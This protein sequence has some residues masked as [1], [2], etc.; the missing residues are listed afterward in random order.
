MRSRAGRP[1]RVLMLVENVPIVR[2]HRL[3]K[4]AG[5]LVENGLR[6]TVICPRGA[7]NDSCV[8]GVRVLDYPAPREGGRKIDFMIEYAWSI[9]AAAVLTLRVFVTAGFDVLQI[10]STPDIYFTVAWPFRLLRRRI[11]LDFKDVSP[12]MYV[13][14][15]GGAGGTMHRLLLMME[16]ANLRCAHRVLVVNESLRD[17]ARDRGGVPDQAITI[18]GN[19]PLPARLGRRPERPELRGRHQKLC[20]WVGMIGPQDRL[21]LAI[22][23]FG[24]LVHDLGRTDCGFTVLGVGDALPDAERLVRELDLEKWVDFFGWAVE[25]QVFDH[26]S[27][28]DLG[29]EPDVEDFVSPVKAMEFMSVGLPFVAFDVRETRAMARGAA[30]Y[31]PRGDAEAMAKLVDGLLDDPERRSAMGR[32][33]EARVRD[34][35]G[36]DHQGAR[37]VRVLRDLTERDLTE[38][39]LTDG[40]LTD[41]GL[42]E[43]GRM[44]RP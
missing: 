8:P 38:R 29:L 43:R 22:R 11:V 44:E 33:G 24:H 42:T 26:L 30:V 10:S 5:T 21:D 9:L 12:E 41:G 14:R 1:T 35:L 25:D 39:D 31:A 2:D 4:L 15:F 28:A 27:T 16:R 18:V 6:V 17:I 40:G 37:Y 36:W 32:E 3:R 20:V 7:G 23:A 34:E 13:A 19:G